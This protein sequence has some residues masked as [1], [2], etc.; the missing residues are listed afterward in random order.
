MDIIDFEVSR[1]KQ[2]ADENAKRRKK[3]EKA[4]TAQHEKDELE[5]QDQR[6]RGFV[7][8]QEQALRVAFYLLLNLSEDARVEEKMGKKSF[9]INY[10][11]RFIFTRNF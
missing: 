5:R 10:V 2:Y 1:Y 6:Y 9:F 7:K 8:K 4:A 11:F 3:K